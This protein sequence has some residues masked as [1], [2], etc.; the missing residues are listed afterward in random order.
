M[1]IKNLKIVLTQKCKNA[2]NICKLDKYRG[3]TLGVDLSIF[4][5]KYIYNNGDHIEGLTRLILRLLK[6]QITPVFVLDGKPPEE[7]KNTLQERKDK[8]EYLY[9]KKNV[10][11]SCINIEKNDYNDFKNHINEIIEKNKNESFIIK[12]DEIKE[13][14]NKSQDELR[15]EVEKVTKKIIHVTYHHI[16]SSKKLFDLFG[17]RHIYVQQGGEAEGI[18]SMLSKNNVIQGIITE[19][20]DILANSGKLLLKNFCPDKNTIE[21]NCLDGILSC[22]EL[23]QDEFIDFCIL[24]GCDYTQKI[25]NLGPINALK[26]IYKYKNIEKFLDNNTKYIIPINFMD[27]Y[28]KARYLFNHPIPDDVY[29]TIDKD[30][31]MKEPKIE[32]LK[33]FLK[34]SKLKE[35]YFKDIENN[36]MNYFLNIDGIYQY[37]NNKDINILTGKKQK[38]RKIT[39]FF[40]K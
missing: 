28:Q 3:Y 29:D 33:D 35:K 2:I 26:I 39:D 31:K 30:T 32:E 21:E 17:I 16:E 12:D 20:S 14:F 15:F 25:P 18:L 40:G 7:K 27:N 1:G 37:E 23:N 9:I 13:L 19:D 11:E 4:L 24:C 34:D 10:L 38:T 36:L 5:Y 6:N 22:L 8:K